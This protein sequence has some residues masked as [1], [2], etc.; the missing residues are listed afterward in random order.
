MSTASKLPL[1]ALALTGVLAACQN[2]EGPG[3]P[4]SGNGNGVGGPAV[5]A[6]NATP[7]PSPARQATTQLGDEAIVLSTA[8]GAVEI[9]RTPLQLSFTDAAGNPVLESPA[10]PLLPFQVR[11]PLPDRS[12]GGVETPQ[13]T[14]LYAPF[15]FIVGALAAQQ[16]PGSFWVGNLLAAGATGIEY[17]LTDVTDVRELDNGVELTVATS[18]PTGRTATVTVQPDENDTFRVSLRLAPVNNQVPLVAAAFSSEAGEAFRGFGGRRNKL[19]QRGED[20]LNWAEGFSQTP[21]AA[22]GPANPL[23]PEQFQFPTGPQGAYYVQSLFYSSRGYGF[24]LENAELSHWRMA[25]DRDDV[26]QV[27]VAGSGMDFV[28]AVGD[29]PTAINKITGLNGRHRMPP[30]WALGPMLS[31]TIQINTDTAESYAA[32]LAESV[33]KIEELD[34]P[35]TAFSIEGWIALEEVGALESTIARMRAQGIM[36]LAYFKGFVDSKDGEYEDH[37]AFEEATEQGYVAT[38]ITGQP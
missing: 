18:D 38:R 17:V 28:V 11:P 19:D 9:Q 3:S 10:A 33:D 5:E 16:F 6:S 25:S 15:S 7:P 27:E 23:F 30:E 35:V 14:P 12:P 8:A 26:W 37:Q 1:L 2:S 21:D 20:F 34:L 32:K 13:A 31:E 24:L 22:V 36:P 29:G 4:A